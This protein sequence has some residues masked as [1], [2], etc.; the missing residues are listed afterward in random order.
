MN[1]VFINLTSEPRR[2]LDYVTI[3]DTI[4]GGQAQQWTVED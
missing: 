2:P 1:L 3:S 4:K